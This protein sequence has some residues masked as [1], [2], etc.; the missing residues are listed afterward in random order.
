MVEYEGG[1][2]AETESTLQGE[3]LNDSFM[4][5]WPRDMFIMDSLLIIHDSYM[6]PDCFHIFNK[7]TGDFIQSFGK[8]GRG[9]GEFIDIGS[10]SYDDVSHLLT[11]FDPNSKKIVLFDMLKIVR[12]ERPFYEEIIIGEAPN[13]VKRIIQNGDVFI[14][15]G[16]DYRM[17]YGIWNPTNG[18][19]ENIYADFPNLTEDVEANWSIADNSVK[20]RL[21]PDRNRLVAGTY[22]GGVL[23]I[24]D[25]RKDGFSPSEVRYFFEP[26][27]KYADGAVPR[28]VAAL[29]ETKIGFEDIFL[30]KNA[31]YALT[32]GV[33]KEML[34][35]ET[36][37]IIKFD[38][39][40]NPAVR[41][42]VD[43]SLE[44][45]VVD[46]DR[47]LYGVGQNAEGEYSLNRYV[48]PATK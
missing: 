3:M 9:P 34:G 7:N 28:Y 17:R 5:N 21:S 2:F 25:V 40:G 48:L 20:L 4:F 41:F 42:F 29:P 36:P 15:N 46:E 13:F 1:I 45:I 6:Q 33:D 8:I 22:I 10:A 37:E 44:A 47:T 30:T 35:Q 27:F 12:N 18:Q 16:N 32:W 24:F 14:A 19:F 38:Y 39:S 11:V 31:I 26:V 23:E 43:K